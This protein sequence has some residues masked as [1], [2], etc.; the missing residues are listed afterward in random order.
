[1]QSKIKGWRINKNILWLSN[2]LMFLTI[3]S[4]PIRS[5]SRNRT[6]CESCGHRMRMIP[7]PHSP[8]Y[9]GPVMRSAPG[10]VD[11]QVKK[12][13]GMVMM[14]FSEG[15]WMGVCFWGA[16]WPSTLHSKMHPKIGCSSVYLIA[17]VG[18]KWSFKL[19]FEWVIP[20][21]HIVLAYVYESILKA[22]NSLKN[23]C[24]F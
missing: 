11:N 17:I 24:C 18:Q 22:K 4:V 20:H 1:M 8:C 21:V 23:K 2:S 15:K 14:T 13:T 3:L 19:D 16:C 7:G 6:Y 5:E 10:A 12:I 9:P